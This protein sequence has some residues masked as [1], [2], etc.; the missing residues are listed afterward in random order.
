MVASTNETPVFLP[1]TAVLMASNSLMRSEKAM[2]SVGQTKVK[3]R[4]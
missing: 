2:I 3:S 4:G 1:S